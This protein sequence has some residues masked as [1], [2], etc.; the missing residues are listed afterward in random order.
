MHYHLH[1]YLWNILSGIVENT[2]EMHSLIYF[3]EM[4]CYVGTVSICILQVTY[5]RIGQL[6]VRQSRS[7]LTW[8][9]K[10]LLGGLLVSA[11]PED[12]AWLFP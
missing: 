2:L 12:P 11:L 1:K 10:P 5:V 7:N 3:K 9:P 6:S 4:P 8:T